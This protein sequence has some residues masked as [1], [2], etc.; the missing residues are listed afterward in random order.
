MTM[1]IGD[2]IRKRC[3]DVLCTTL[4]DRIDSDC[5]RLPTVSETR[6]IQTMGTASK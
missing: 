3:A 5:P 1:K 2:E 6:H 4:A